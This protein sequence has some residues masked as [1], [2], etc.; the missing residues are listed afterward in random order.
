MSLIVTLSGSPS[1]PSRTQLLA[2]LVGR[3]L[4]SD[5]FTVERLNVRDLPA[6]DLLHGRAQSDSSGRRWPSSNGPTPWWWPRRS[7]RRLTAAC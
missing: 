7:T 2:N 3:R 5:G 6:E 4:A 1:H